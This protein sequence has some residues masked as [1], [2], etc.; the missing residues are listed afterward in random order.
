MSLSSIELFHG[1]NGNMCRIFGFRS[2]LQSGVHA[3]L[4]SA[5]NALSCQSRRHPDGWGLAYYLQG[6]PHVV[7]STDTAETDELFRKLSGLVSSETVLAHVRKATHGKLSLVNTHPFQHG[8]W[9]FAHN[10]NIRDFQKLRLALI[11]LIPQNFQRWCLGET[12]SE[13]FFLFLLSRLGNSDA[14]PV[15][16]KL[17][18][19]GQAVIDLVNLIGPLSDRETGTPTENYLSFVLTDGRELYA[20]QGGLTLHYSTHKKR[21]PERDSCKS[22]AALC[23][24]PA[25]DNETVNHLIVSS[26]PL[27]G[28]NVWVKMGPGEMVAVDAGMRLFRHSVALPLAR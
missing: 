1:Y 7:K 18:V 21:C 20:L 5:E 10:G 17:K 2:V 26:E 25:Q 15:T 4:V 16:E 28:D 6:A 27:Q 24:K 9:T 12:D 3:S 13:V 23:E 8:K 22:F 19:L 11:H 14:L